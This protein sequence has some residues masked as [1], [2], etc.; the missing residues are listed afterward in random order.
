MTVLC[1]LL[2][3]ALAALITWHAIASR[4]RACPLPA[5]KEQ[6]SVTYPD[7]IYSDGSPWPGGMVRPGFT[8]VVTIREVQG[9]WVRFHNSGYPP[10]DSGD[11]PGDRRERLEHFVRRFSRIEP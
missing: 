9:G 10:D 8:V 3:L 6:W 2:I 4:K 1:L 11:G 7:Q 5:P